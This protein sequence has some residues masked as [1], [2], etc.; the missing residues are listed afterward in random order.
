MKHRRSLK[1][2]S[3]PIHQR[4]AIMPNARRPQPPSFRGLV[5][6]WHEIVKKFMHLYETL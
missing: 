3:A 5:Y 4:S 6:L 1:S 2:V